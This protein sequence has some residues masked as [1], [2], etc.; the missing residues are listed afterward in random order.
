MKKIMQRLAQVAVLTPAIALYATAAAQPMTALPAAQAAES[1]SPQAAQT[2]KIEAKKYKF[3][4]A[5]ITLKKG[6]TV[7]LELTS[8]DVRH[9]LVVKG[10][11]INGD[12][13]KGKITNVTVTPEKT[14]DFKGDCGVFCGVGHHKMHF[15][16]HVVNP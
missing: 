15:V 3:I 11:G 14:G 13:T 8:D 1:A 7:N 2:I 9:S 12:M 10:L 6:E 4:P 5:E 16:V